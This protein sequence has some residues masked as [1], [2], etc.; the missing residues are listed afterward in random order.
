M[1]AL[2]TGASSGLGRDMAKVL[3]QM[4]L[5]VIL[6]ARRQERLIE[7]AQ[8]L[9]HQ[10]QVIV[11]DLSHADN[12][13]QLYEQLQ[14]QS[15]DILINNAGF[16]L[17]GSFEQSSLDE[18]LRLIDTNVRAVH[19]LTK[20]FLKDFKKR[21]SGYI[22]N[23]ASSA[24]FLPGPL[25]SGYYASKSYVFRLSEGIREE[26][27]HDHSNVHISVL[28]PGPVNT[29]FNQKAHVRFALKGLESYPVA[30]YAITELFKGKF[31]ILP[32]T[33]VKI[34]RPLCKIVPDSILARF[35]YHFQKRKGKAAYE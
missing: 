24:A 31:L 27:R 9:R 6:V 34:L 20:L 5:E 1:K 18:E 17:F 22:L 26:L 16:G 14:D 30:Q 8:E 15:I 21:D 4:G 28:C 32:G 7:L 10:A 2:I 13:I 19:M 11:A 29:E 33:M 3:D 12:C 25:L 23:V 35:A